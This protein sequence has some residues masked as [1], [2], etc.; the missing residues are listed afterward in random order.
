LK[1]ILVDNTVVTPSKIICVGRNYVEHV[2]ELNN[3]M[4]DEPVIFLKPNGA[5][6]QQL[7][8]F[9]NTDSLHYEGEICFVYDDNNFSAVGFGLDIT[10]RDLQTR[11]KTKG[12][13]WE[14]AKAFDGSAV[15]S[16]FVSID[17][18]PDN[19]RLE[20]Y[21]NGLLIQEGHLDH[22]MFKPDQV[23]SNLSQFMHLNQ[24]DVVM[25]GTPKG[26]GQIM[27]GDLFYAKIMVDDDILTQ[28]EWQ[29]VA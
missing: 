14:R 28:A 26:V 16:P 20:L 5:I 12:L 10:K 13:P 18:I 17:R 6:S 1:T 7:I 25:T 24:G 2:K 23:L 9:H 4:P 15:F 27:D 29:A 3:E 19:L 11:L 8:C 21:I 22:M